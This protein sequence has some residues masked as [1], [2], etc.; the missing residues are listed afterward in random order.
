MTDPNT[1]TAADDL[2]KAGVNPGDLPAAAA[3][4]TALANAGSL[5]RRYRK[6]PVEITAAH[7]TDA[8]A[9]GRIAAWAGGSNER[10]PH[11]IQI[12]TP[13]GT[14]T[15]SLGDYVIRGVAG[16]FYPCKPEIFDATYEPATG[17]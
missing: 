1:T 14:M 3:G 13:E 4:A 5:T 2:T 12:E 15:A 17:N 10:S 16:E 8:A 11:E 7:F 9:G 6:K